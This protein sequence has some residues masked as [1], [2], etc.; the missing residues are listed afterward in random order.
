MMIGVS[1]SET[2]VLV[3]TTEKVTLLKFSIREFGSVSVSG[4]QK[5][6]LEPQ[7]RLAQFLPHASTTV[8]NKADGDGRIFMPEQLGNTLSFP[9]SPARPEPSD[10]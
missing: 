2:I 5:L 1:V 4:S 8:D 3:N 7:K 6:S 10:C 9:Q